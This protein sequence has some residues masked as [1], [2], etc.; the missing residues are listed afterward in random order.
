MKRSC[1]DKCDTVYQNCIKSVM[2]ISRDEKKLCINL[3]NEC[4]K[5]PKCSRCFSKCQAT[6]ERCYEQVSDTSRL[7]KTCMKPFQQCRRKC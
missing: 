4:L 6:Y 5:G 2:N 1:T 7:Y 3:N